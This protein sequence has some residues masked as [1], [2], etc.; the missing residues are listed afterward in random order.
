M[1]TNLE[2]R[3]SSNRRDTIAVCCIAIAVLACFHMLVLHPNDLLVGPQHGGNNDLTAHFIAARNFPNLSQQSGQLPLWNPST[4]GG[5]PYCGNPQSALFYPPNWIYYF[6]SPQTTISWLL[7]LHQFW[8]G[9]GMYFLCRRYECARIASVGGGIVFAAAPYLMAHTGEGHYNQICVVSWFPWALLAFERFRHGRA[10]GTALVAMV[11]ALS[12]FAG[13]AQEVYYLG[14]TLTALAIWDSL[15][16][17]R[18]RRREEGTRVLCR[19]LFAGCAA[20]GLVAIDLVPTW[21]YTRQAVRATGLGIEEAGVGLEAANLTQ[22]INP[23]AL[24][25]PD[26][27]DRP[28]R[29]FW[30]TICHFGI[31][32]LLL[33]VVAA[34]FAWRRYPVQRLMAIS[35]TSLLFAF[36]AGS[37]VFTAFYYVVPMASS[38][39]MPCRA[40]FV[41]TLSLAVLT[42]VGIDVIARVR[43]RLHFVCAGLAILC[44]V[45]LGL[46]SVGILRTIPA[47]AV[48]QRNPVL[49]Q[50]G[51]R[52]GHHRV[53]AQQKLFSDREAA[54]CGIQ[55]VQGY[56][57]VPLVAAA[58]IIDV[59]TPGQDP[60][61]T[62]V[63]FDPIDLRKLDKATVDLFGVR[64]AVVGPAQSDK[65]NGWKMV[66][67]GRMVDQFTLRSHRSTELP[68]RIYENQS[69]MPRAFVVGNVRE[70]NGQ[71]D[72]AAALA[73]I[74][75]RSEV[76]LNEDLL[77][78]GKRSEFRPAKIVEYSPNRVA[79]EAELD[80]P[81]YLVLTD[82]WYP[83]WQAE[84]NDVRVPIL[85]ANAAFR[86]VP[87]AAGNHRIV[88]RYSTPGLAVGSMVTLGV[89]FL[90]ILSV[91]RP[92]AIADKKSQKNEMDQAQSATLLEE[93]TIGG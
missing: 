23:W 10:G 1:V 73:S 46:F 21:I 32:P 78:T 72:L 9:V 24:G 51:E 71:E 26:T 7:V 47:E 37:I 89:I 42:A 40:L 67:E 83:G 17:F 22:L 87:L 14:L 64:F 65:L 77:P 60:A 53:I 92:P 11:L 91:A 52:V 41:C 36:G 34:V 29:F 54:E 6:A 35:V 59:M 80:Y 82:I 25:G 56:D 86:A 88:F 33:A 68:Y 90:M 2:S 3:W 70:R 5:A 79:I 39:R 81:G 27:Y 15:Q 61:H 31:A 18:K 13:H 84:V 19:W 30:E 20:L 85:P 74:E 45:E 16:H 38:F 75:P 8:G 62:V 49:A 58:R 55:K 66:D 4:L 69:V 93:V 44:L 76:L 28:G 48:R 57:P 12:F 63:G 50:I 43:R